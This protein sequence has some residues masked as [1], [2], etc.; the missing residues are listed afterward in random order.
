[1][2]AA[3]DSDLAAVRGHLRRDR[4]CLDRVFEVPGF[5][6]RAALHQAA[7]TDR[8]AVV[9]FLLA[10]GAAVDVRSSTGP[11]AQSR[12]GAAAGASDACGAEVGLRC[13]M[14][15]FTAAWRMPSCCWRRRPRWT[16]RTTEAGGLSRCHIRFENSF[17]PATTIIVAVQYGI[18]FDELKF[19]FSGSFNFDGHGISLDFSSQVPV[20][21]VPLKFKSRDFG[22][23]LCHHQRSTLLF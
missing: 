20:F 3:L 10:K 9:A 21:K 13:M 18:C 14:Q 17:S 5:A 1:M 11:G 19:E 8:T 6:R 15:H 16:S 22:A 23:C 4:R 12:R 2:W 7:G